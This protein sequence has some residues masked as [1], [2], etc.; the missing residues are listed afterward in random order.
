MDEKQEAFERMA[1]LINQEHL[2]MNLWEVYEEVD[3]TTGMFPSTS[4]KCQ[5]ST[6]LLQMYDQ[7]WRPVQVTLYAGELQLLFKEK[8]R[9]FR[10]ILRSVLSIDVSSTTK[11]VFVVNTPSHS[12]QLRCRHEIAAVDWVNSLRTQIRLR[13]KT[14]LQQFF[15]FAGG[16]RTQ[17]STEPQCGSELL[18]PPTPEN[19]YKYSGK[20]LL[21]NCWVGIVNELNGKI[22]NKKKIKK[23][24]FLIGRSGSADFIVKK[25]PYVSRTQC[26][27]SIVDNIPYLVDMGQSV[28]GTFLNSTYVTQAPIAPGDFLTVGRTKL[29]FGITK[30]V[31][32]SGSVKKFSIDEDT[33]FKL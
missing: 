12:F 10:I 25:D 6:L 8:S 33:N 32:F 27:I 16:S 11:E 2:T 9:M 29:V 3:S 22:K 14:L 26:K 20:P 23:D 17:P 21:K 31:T 7:K 5:Q 1:V 4:S 30:K 19:S 13:D 18:S 28:K 24:T 15:S